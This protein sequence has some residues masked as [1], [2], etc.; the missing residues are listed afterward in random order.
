MLF[1]Y[2]FENSITSKGSV[3]VIIVSATNSLRKPGLND[4]LSL[5]VVVFK[6]TVTKF[7]S[8]VVIN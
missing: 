4:V 3:N 7:I 1:L 2:H 6:A 8:S 5:F